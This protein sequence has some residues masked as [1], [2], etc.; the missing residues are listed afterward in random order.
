MRSSGILLQEQLRS[1]EGSTITPKGRLQELK[2]EGKTPWKTPPPVFSEPETPL[3]AVPAS[4]WQQ[5]CDE[6]GEVFATSL[7]VCHHRSF[8]HH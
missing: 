8:N 4:G 7:I 1:A 2:A 5:H 3:T 6:E